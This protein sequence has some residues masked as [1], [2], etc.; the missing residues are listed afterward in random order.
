MNKPRL[1][2]AVGFFVVGGFV[3][4]A[5]VVF[6]VSGVY[7]FRPGYFI[8]ATFGHV[9]I[10]DRGAPVRYAGVKVGEVKKV[11]IIEGSGAEARHVRLTLFVV[12][13][14]NVYEHDEISIR[15]THIM[16]EPHVEID[17]AEVRGRRL[18]SGEEVKGIDPISMDDLIQQGR[19]IATRINR[20]LVEMEHQVKDSKS[21][22]AL[23]QSV[24]NL[25]ELTASLNSIVKGNE[26]E[27]RSGFIHFSRSAEQLDAILKQVNEGRGTLGRL[28]VEDELYADLREFV[29][30]I[31]KQPWRLF[32]KS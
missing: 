22:D 28:V 25:S 26:E 2:V 32:K 23:K 12:E 3:L 7:F 29:Q 13:G 19:D 10:I 27:I 18:Q 16:A 30:E 9:G 20:F 17:P 24:I 1:E 31:K 21:R 15:G 6:G 8:H 5:M 11:Q 4:L 14:V